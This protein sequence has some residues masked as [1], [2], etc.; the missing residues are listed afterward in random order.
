M[1]MF[2]IIRSGDTLAC[3][4]M[5]PMEAARALGAG[6]KTIVGATIRVRLSRCGSAMGDL[7]GGVLGP[8]SEETGARAWAS[9]RRRR[10]T[11]LPPRTGDVSAR[12]PGRSRSA[13]RRR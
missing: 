9:A 7:V 11:R 3:E 1:L 10:G 13:G 4:Q 12:G 6:E 2:S 5:A 8:V